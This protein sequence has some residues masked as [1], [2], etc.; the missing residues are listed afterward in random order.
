MTRGLKITLAG[1]VLLLGWLFAIMVPLNSPLAQGWRIPLRTPER[2][3]PAWSLDGGGTLHGQPESQAGPPGAKSGP[4]VA[5]LLPSEAAAA[6][7]SSTSPGSPP[8]DKTPTG[9]ES[10]YVDYTPDRFPK[11]ESSDVTAAALK[12]VR[13]LES[14]E[15]GPESSRPGDPEQTADASL[16]PADATMTGNWEPQGN[17]VA[18]QQE[19]KEW[20]TEVETTPLEE[21]KVRSAAAPAWKD[22]DSLILDPVKEASKMSQPPRAQEGTIEPTQ[23]AAP[24][25]PDEPQSSGE[26]VAAYAQAKPL[27]E[28]VTESTAADANP[29]L[30]DKKSAEVPIATTVDPNQKEAVPVNHWEPLATPEVSKSPG[31]VVRD[32]VPPSALTESTSRGDQAVAIAPLAATPQP[33]KMGKLIIANAEPTPG[34]QPGIQNVLARPTT[35]GVPDTAQAAATPEPSA[36]TGPLVLPLPTPVRTETLTQPETLDAIAARHK[37]SPEQTEQ[38]LERNRR[39]LAPDGTFPAGTVLVL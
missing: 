34:V 27:A 14:P 9:H 39:K 4:F 11:Q 17:G 2:P 8:E 1:V 31:L 35:G 28:A 16:E 26:V 10:G 22:L 18:R 24:A 15:G 33:L 3:A 37:Y 36:P 7:Q 25:G 30:T 5:D 20:A 29:P 21:P 32:S 13:N 23:A 19:E 38:L 12:S 6:N